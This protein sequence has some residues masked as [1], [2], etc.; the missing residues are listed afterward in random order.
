M[1]HDK[2]EQKSCGCAFL[3]YQIRMRLPSDNVTD[4][5]S[6]SSDARLIRVKPFAIANQFHLL[7]WQHQI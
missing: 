7:H 3:A 1:R 2:C 6:A 4:D 5:I